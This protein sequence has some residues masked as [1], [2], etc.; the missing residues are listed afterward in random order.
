MGSH[1]QPEPQRNTRCP[2]VER[3]TP[4]SGRRTLPSARQAHLPEHDHPAARKARCSGRPVRACPGEACR[5]VAES[6]LPVRWWRPGQTARSGRCPG[7]GGV[8]GAGVLRPGRSGR[9]ERGALGWWRVNPR[10]RVPLAVRGNRTLQ[11]PGLGV[12]ATTRTPTGSGSQE[13]APPGAQ[14][15][16][17]PRTRDHAPTT[18]ETGPPHVTIRDIDLDR[19]RLEFMDSEGRT[20]IRAGGG[21]LRRSAGW[22]QSLTSVRMVSPEPW[23]AKPEKTAACGT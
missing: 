8:S 5:T 15:P 19:L 3:S 4:S 21:P 12:L 18:P 14:P 22:N 23:N 1:E 9:W 6:A 16:D 17:A 20:W 13:A 2:L 11:R 10:E 7:A